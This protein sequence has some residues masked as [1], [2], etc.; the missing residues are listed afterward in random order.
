MHP[1]IVYYADLRGQWSKHGTVRL[2]P[3]CT[4]GVPVVEALDVPWWFQWVVQACWECQ[5]R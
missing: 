4:S 1:L 2:C 3:A 5:A